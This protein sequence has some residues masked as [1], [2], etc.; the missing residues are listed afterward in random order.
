MSLDLDHNEIKHLSEADQEDSNA[1]RYFAPDAPPSRKHA[2]DVRASVGVRACACECACG[3]RV[4]ACECACACGCAC[5]CAG[6]CVLLHVLACTIEIS[7][8]FA[9]VF[10]GDGNISIEN[11]V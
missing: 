6:A 1:V 4:C 8:L 11:R 5:V 9:C 7:T 2:L 3:V 10:S